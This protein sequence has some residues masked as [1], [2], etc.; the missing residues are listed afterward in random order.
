MKSNKGQALIEFVLILPVFLLLLFAI[1]DF[2][3]I[4]YEKNRLESISSDVVD[5]VNNKKLTTKQIERV[6]EKNYQINLTLKIDRKKVNT[7]IMI[8]R[9]I[10][11]ITPGLG[12]AISDP[13]NVEVSRV[14]NS[15]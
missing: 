15:E 10:D 12:I 6:L 13:Y 8:S 5:L 11:V 4:V 7:I 3:R 2:G 1:I 9:K 14:I